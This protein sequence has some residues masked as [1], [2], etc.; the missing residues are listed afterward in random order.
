MNVRYSTI[1]DLDLDKVKK[2]L[3]IEPIVYNFVIALTMLETLAN[4]FG[5]IGQ[6]LTDDI[7]VQYQHSV[8]EGTRNETMS[9]KIML[10]IYISREIPISLAIPVVCLLLIVLRRAFINLPYRIWVGRYIVYILFRLVIMLVMSW[11]YETSKVL[12]VIL[13][14]IVLFDICV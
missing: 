11:F 3:K 14:P 5:G 2:N 13:L 7:N 6:F 12:P 8:E 10:I 4:V 9:N 1:F